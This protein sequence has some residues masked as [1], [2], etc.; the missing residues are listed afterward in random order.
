M[1]IGNEAQVG[2][3]TLPCP[4]TSPERP[5]L[6]ETEAVPQPIRVTVPVPTPFLKCTEK[7]ITSK[8]KCKAPVYV[9]SGRGLAVV[10]VGAPPPPRES[11]SVQVPLLARMVLPSNRP[12]N[13]ASLELRPPMLPRTT[14]TSSGP[15]TETLTLVVAPLAGDVL[16][17]YQVPLPLDKLVSR[18]NVNG[19]WRLLLWQS[20]VPLQSPSAVPGDDDDAVA[21]TDRALASSSAFFCSSYLASAA[22]AS[23]VI[24]CCCDA[25]RKPVG[26]SLR[27]FCHAAII[28]RER[29][30]N[31]PSLPRVSKPSD[32]NAT[33]RRWRS[34][35][36]DAALLSA[37]SPSSFSLA[38]GGGRLVRLGLGFRLDPRLGLGLV[39]L[40][41]GLGRCLVGLS[42]CRCVLLGLALR[43]FGRL[44]ARR[45]LDAGLGPG[46]RLGAACAALPPRPAPG[47]PGVWPRPRP[48]PSSRPPPRPRAGPPLPASA[49]RCA[50]SSTARCAVNASWSRGV[51]SCRRASRRARSSASSC[52]AFSR[53]C[54]AWSSSASACR[55]ASASA[56]AFCRASSSRRRFS[57]ASVSALRR[58]ASA[59]S[60]CS[61]DRL[62]TDVPGDTDVIAR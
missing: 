18:F 4:V 14:V 13:G 29:G 37:A 32:V 62:A 1:G 2:G 61:A 5:T 11:A 54:R 10:G 3:N 36:R 7:R 15:F 6:S 38:S 20:K 44:G 31:T 50:A 60:S 23:F 55:L 45:R 25:V 56:C 35:V 27:A 24:A 47:R 26:G 58:S 49:L 53:A 8:S 30:P 12:D 59:C 42:P 46:L 52:S 34:A 40:G 19:G 41:L 17:A 33:C 16:G 57:A 48:L 51:D 43:L 22:A 28:S 39:A 9:P 21:T